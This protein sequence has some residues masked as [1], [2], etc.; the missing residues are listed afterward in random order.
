MKRHRIPAIAAA[1]FAGAAFATPTLAAPMCYTIYDRQD[2]VVYRGYALPFDGAFD[3]ASAG[4][5][6]MRG[7]GENLVFF[8]AD[9]CVPVAPGGANARPATTDE[10][11]AA[12][13][14]Y[15]SRGVGTGATP[16]GVYASG[17]GAPSPRQ[18]AAVVYGG[19]AARITAPA[20]AAIG[21]RTA[22]YR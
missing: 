21:A 5:Q 1:L 20:A 4:R 22:T 18:G 16:G 17:S 14:A 3:P 10:I 6:A 2:E 11:V 9:Y 19:P 13:P 12:I 8:E 15:G 7:R